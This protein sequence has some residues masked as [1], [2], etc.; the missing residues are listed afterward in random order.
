VAL[1]RLPRRVQDGPHPHVYQGRASRPRGSLSE[2]HSIYKDE[3]PSAR[4]AQRPKKKKQRTALARPSPIHPNSAS[5]PRSSD[6]F[7]KLPIRVTAWRMP[8]LTTDYHVPFN[9]PNARASNVDI[10]LTLVVAVR[11]HRRSHG[12]K[13]PDP[14]RLHDAPLQIYL[15][16]I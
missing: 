15:L 14:P 7:S 11:A 3:N 16:G 9:L 13:L 5:R 4:A 1:V 10:A 12:R 2:G 6:P 8:F